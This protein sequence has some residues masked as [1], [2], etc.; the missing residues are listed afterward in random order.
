[1]AFGRDVVATTAWSYR[2]CRAAVRGIGRELLGDGQGKLASQEAR[3]VGEDDDG[4]SF[5]D[6]GFRILALGHEVIR[7]A[8]GGD[9]DIV[10][11]EIAGDEAAPTGGAEF[12][13]SHGDKCCGSWVASSGQERG[14]RDTTRLMLPA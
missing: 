7:H 6:L 8:L 5:G 13:G 3:V 2:G 12:N 1:M 14:L 10:K 11:G 9:T 4:L